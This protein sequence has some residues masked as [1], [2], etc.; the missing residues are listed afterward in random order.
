[1]VTLPIFMHLLVIAFINLFLYF[2]VRDGH[3]GTHLH[4]KR[5]LGKPPKLDNEFFIDP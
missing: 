3:R 4:L 5:A 2:C 1:M